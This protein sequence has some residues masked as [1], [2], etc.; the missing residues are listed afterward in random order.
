MLVSKEKSWTKH[1]EPI[2]NSKA[3]FYYLKVNVYIW[4]S[5]QMPKL[6]LIPTWQMVILS[7]FR[8]TLK[9]N[10]YFKMIKSKERNKPLTLNNN[11]AI[12]TWY[13]TNFIHRCC[14]YY[15][16]YTV[17]FSWHHRSCVAGRH[18]YQVCGI[19]PLR[20]DNIKTC[21][22]NSKYN[23]ENLLRRM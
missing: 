5:M 11:Y 13:H 8:Q 2:F 9:I 14:V 22:Q 21:Y 1:V 12:S 6:M 16:T 7:I 17:K 4:M 18:H 20:Y 19:I 10:L 3:D 23:R 15:T